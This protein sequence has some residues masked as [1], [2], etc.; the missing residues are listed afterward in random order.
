MNTEQEK[1]WAKTYSKDYI[2][3]NSNF[4]DERGREGWAKMLASADNIESI[5]E[6]GSN[7]GRNIGFLNAVLPDA[8]KSLIELSEQAYETGSSR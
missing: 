1:F 6:C 2:S 4:D 5:L 3:K 8:E 7:I